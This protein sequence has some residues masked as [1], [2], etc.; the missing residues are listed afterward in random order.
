MGVGR[1]SGPVK[2][3]MSGNQLTSNVKSL[4][5]EEMSSLN[6]TGPGVMHRVVFEIHTKE[7]WYGILRDAVR[8]FGQHGFRSQG[9][10]LRKLK[11]GRIGIMTNNLNIRMHH[12]NPQ[13]HFKLN[14]V[15]V[16]FDVPSLPWV[17]KIVIK[18]G[19]NHRVVD[20]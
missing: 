4:C 6:Q 12:H 8:E 1:K 10:V 20:R 14:A 5:T 18:Y 13:H 19:L 15:P 17:L 3:Y 7:Q 16:W 9:R 11:E 2:G